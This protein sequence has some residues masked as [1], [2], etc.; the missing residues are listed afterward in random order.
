MKKYE[1]VRQAQDCVT[2]LTVHKDGGWGFCYRQ[3]IESP[4]HN[5]PSL[6]RDEA[7]KLRRAHLVHHARRL[8]GKPEDYKEGKRN[9]IENL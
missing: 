7:I 5:S 3:S 9:W 6:P 1:A 8:L 4:W 2:L